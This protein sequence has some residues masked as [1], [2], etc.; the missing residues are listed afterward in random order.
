MMKRMFNIFVKPLT[1]NDV[2][3]NV[4]PLIFKANI[5][6]LVVFIPKPVAVI[7]CLSEPFTLYVIFPELLHQA[8]FVLFLFA[9]IIFQL[10]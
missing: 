10:F 1:F 9:L 7:I 5:P 2:D 6:G 8:L 3:K 4:P